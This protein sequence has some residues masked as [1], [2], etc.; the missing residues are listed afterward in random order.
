MM[1]KGTKSILTI[2][3]LA[4]GAAV[5]TIPGSARADFVGPLVE[6]SAITQPAALTTCASEQDPL[7]FGNVVIDDEGNLDVVLGGAG[8]GD[9]YNV[10]FR[11]V[12]GSTLPLGSL[13]TG[14]N[15]NSSHFKYAALAFGKN[16]AGFVVLQRSDVNGDQYVTSLFVRPG[17]SMITRASF[18]VDLMACSTVN[19]PK[20]ITGCGTDTFKSGSV[21][22]RSDTGDVTVQINGAE[23]GATYNVALR[24]P[25]GGATL[26]LGSVG[27]TNGSG[28]ATA[29]MATVPASTIAGGTVVLTNANTSDTG[30]QAY[31]GVRVSQKE[32]KV[33]VVGERLIK[34]NSINF[35]TT[36]TALDANDNCGSDPLT[37]G[38]VV[39]GST[40]KLTVSVSGA[41]DSTTYEV[42]FRPVDYTSAGDMDLG[43]ALTTD[44]SG[45]GK[46]VGSPFTS[47]DIG[48]GIFVLKST[49]MDAGLDEFFSGFQI[50]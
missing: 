44:S 25:N 14:K 35:P 5:W 45:D 26:A 46:A 49:G 29:T 22:V 42:F 9:T 50:K 39:L 3:A 18:H 48:A 7:S 34:C 28:D 12:D 30:D 31:G 41:A 15:G 6:C 33:P 38:S 16:A 11:S 20:A 19:D 10:V 13:T 27:P 21:D 23:V 36:A 4:L 47:G 37:G 8:Q 32:P 1:M 40:G 24:S 2:A 17:A 43:I